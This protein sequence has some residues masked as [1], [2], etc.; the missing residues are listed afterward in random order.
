[1]LE[2]E[3]GL[4][5]EWPAEQD[6]RYMCASLPSLGVQPEE[7]LAVVLR[8]PREPVPGEVVVGNGGDG[9]KKSPCLSGMV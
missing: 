4:T 8:E 6:G 2:A 3:Q 1:M 9:N 5:P 7:A